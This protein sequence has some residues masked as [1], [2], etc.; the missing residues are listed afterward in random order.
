MTWFSS[1]QDVSAAGVAVEEGSKDTVTAEDRSL[2]P[3]EA[4]SAK[5]PGDEKEK[6]RAEPEPAAPGRRNSLLRR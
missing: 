4:A 2:A 6:A 3:K 5:E 1:G